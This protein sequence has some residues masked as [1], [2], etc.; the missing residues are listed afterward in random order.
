MDPIT[1]LERLLRVG[2][3]LFVTNG[4][5]EYVFGISL[6]TVERVEFQLKETDP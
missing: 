2:S 3:E 1:H 6:C 4:K 5:S